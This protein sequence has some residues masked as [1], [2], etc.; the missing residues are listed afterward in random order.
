MR[1]VRTDECARHCT[2]IGGLV[3]YFAFSALV[4]YI[5]VW[6][7]PRGRPGALLRLPDW[8]GEHCGLGNLDGAF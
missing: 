4:V 2:D 7:W 6:V 5:T 8:Q 3:I 1:T